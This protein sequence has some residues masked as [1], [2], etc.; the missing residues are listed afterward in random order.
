MDPYV[1]DW[2]ARGYIEETTALVGEKRKTEIERQKQWLTNNAYFLTIPWVDIKQLPDQERNKTFAALQV[3]LVH[4]AML[5]G[6]EFPQE[7]LW[8]LMG[9]PGSKDHNYFVSLA[10]HRSK[11]GRK[12]TMR[13]HGFE[14]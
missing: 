4:N 3:N 8:A 13:G 9:R 5:D 6:Q 14:E 7:L 10:E 1:N 12:N 2:G 11:A